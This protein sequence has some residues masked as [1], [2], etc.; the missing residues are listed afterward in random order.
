[1]NAD[2][3]T[4]KQGRPVWVKIEAETFEEQRIVKAIVELLEEGGT[5]LIETPTTE[6]KF[7]LRDP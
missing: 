1:M 4:D 7:R 6:T 5:A 2:V 3:K